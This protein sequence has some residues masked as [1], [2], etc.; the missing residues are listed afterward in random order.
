MSLVDSLTISNAAQIS[1][2]DSDISIRSDGSRGSGTRNDPYNGSTL[3]LLD[4]ILFNASSGIA[5]H[6]GPGIF[7][8]NGF[9]GANSGWR[10][11]NGQR[12]IGAAYGLLALAGRRIK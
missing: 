2:A 10:V 3:I 12:F 6:F 7:Q 9:G 11:S 1:Q 5:I 4:T 8:T